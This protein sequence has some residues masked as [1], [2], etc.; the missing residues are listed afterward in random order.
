MAITITEVPDSSA[1]GCLILALIGMW[2]PG[3]SASAVRYLKF[4]KAATSNT[5]AGTEYM[6]IERL[7]RRMRKFVQCKVIDNS[8]DVSKPLSS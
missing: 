4:A 6:Y 8:E 7:P 3:F 1:R 2:L 5:S